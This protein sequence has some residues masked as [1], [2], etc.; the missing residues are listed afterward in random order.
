MRIALLIKK[1]DFGGAEN[2]VCD[3]ANTLEKH[4]HTVLILAGEGKQVIRLNPKIQY[5]HFR[6][7]ELVIPFQ[8]FVLVYYILKNRIEIIHAHQRLPIFMACVIRLITGIPVVATVHG[9]TKYDLRSWFT[10][11]CTSRIIFV[12]QKVQLYSG[13]YNELQKKTHFIP[14]GIYPKN[15]KVNMIP[16]RITYISRLD[17][18]HAEVV[19]ML[20][21]QVIPELVNRFPD[22]SFQIIGTGDYYEQIKSEAFLLNSSDNERC[23]LPGYVHQLD[24]I[25]SSSSIVLGVGRVALESLSLG[26]S[27]LSVNINHLGDL[28][29]TENYQHYRINNFVAVQHPKPKPDVFITLLTDFF[30]NQSYWHEHT[31]KLQQK[32]HQDFN[33]DKLVYEVE[34][35]YSSLLQGKN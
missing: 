5:I 29:S 20:I 19:L 14:N 17:K 4:G 24:D 9:R 35:V 11:R 22:I 25:I 27:V 16:F 31:V 2:H 33:L 3:L 10:R 13:K 12:S 26:I 30:S 7:R 34:E 1:F 6:I 21:K 18:K 15:L 28:I 23:T 8:L 32:V